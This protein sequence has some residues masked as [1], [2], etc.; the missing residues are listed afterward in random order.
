MKSIIDKVIARIK[1]DY[2]E[3]FRTKI[4]IKLSLYGSVFFGLFF[5]LYLII[6]FHEGSIFMFSGLVSQVILIQLFIHKKLSYSLTFRFGLASTVVLLLLNTLYT[7]G[8]YSHTLPWLLIVPVLSNLILE[9]K[10]DNLFWSILTL[11]ILLSLS[12]LSLYD[13]TII[14][15]IKDTDKIL[16]RV[17]SYGGFTFMLLFL[18]ALFEKKKNHFYK[19]LL[20]KEIQIQESIE[21]KKTKESLLENQERWKFAIEGSNDGIWDYN[22]E[23]GEVYR[24]T[25]WAEILGYKKE[26][27]SGSIEEWKNRIHPDD[28]ELVESLLQRH[29][30][31]EIESYSS[32]HRIRCKDGTYKWVLDRGKVIAWTNSGKPKRVV[33]TKTDI[34]KRKIAEEELKNSQGKLK[35]IFNGSNDA[36]LLLTEKGFFDCNPKALEMFQIKYHSDISYIHPADI[37]PE[38]QP[39]GENSLEMANRMI[40]IA[41]EKGSNRFEWEHM[42]LNGETFPAEVLLSA[43]NYGEERVLQSTV[44]DITERKLANE[45]IKQSEEKYRSLVENSPE[46][47]LIINSDERIE[48]LN[49]A[50]QR[51]DQQKIIGDSL[52]NYVHERHHQEIKLANERVLSG[53]VKYETYETQGTDING[54]TQ[55]FQTHIGPKYRDDEVVGLVLFIRNITDRK[56]SEEKI[57]QSLTEK[58]VLLKE[59]HHRVKNNLQIISSIL[60]LQ[61]S[62]ISDQH[63]LELLKNSQ[64]RIRSMSLIH[65]LLYQ[66][67][68]FSTI[69][70]SEYIKSIATN[71]FH[72]YNQNKNI[73]LDLDLDDIHLDLDMAIPCGLIVNELLTNS[74]KYAFETEDEG[75][76]RV[77]LKSKNGFVHLIITD[78][79]KG[80]PKDIDFRDTASLG[81]QLV[82]SLVDQIDG[83]VI[84]NT[85]K[86][87]EYEITFK[88]PS[89][90][91]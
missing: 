69:K 60:N 11:T 7:G 33:G 50:S 85:E 91:A 37:S 61:S 9:N 44:Q 72:S 5:I 25:K 74:L 71:L 87:S 17:C 54:K 83:E 26:E 20:I 29:F 10:K 46:I 76:I 68:D 82:V 80:F 75:I 77:K 27:I 15:R 36:I 47:I 81:M 66:T 31:K 59:V 13:Y 41:F 30:N 45:K 70:F 63:T 42:R 4:L 53:E 73:S 56:L 23:T 89:L 67:K 18:T 24:S 1:K 55:Y 28:K 51:Y 19:E 39:N 40:Q 84:L 58:E 48:F 16:T 6:G 79:G 34:T 38:F 57:K 14:N 65:E 32:E 86:G 52:Y 12:G 90:N 21:L 64:D 3:S 43:F 88:A 49:F 62:T 35:A 78:N 22:L 8:I 2:R